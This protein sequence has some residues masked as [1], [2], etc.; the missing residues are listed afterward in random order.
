MATQADRQTEPQA[1]PRMHTQTEFGPYPAGRGARVS[2]LASLL[3]LLGLFHAPMLPPGF[4]P[5]CFMFLISRRSSLIS[6][7]KATFSCTTTAKALGRLDQTQWIECHESAASTATLIN[8]RFITGS[9]PHPLSHPFIH[10]STG[11][12][13]DPPANRRIN[14]PRLCLESG[15]S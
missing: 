14:P 2:G 1:D 11:Q 9:F 3:D 15:P 13:T 5:T 4:S 6:R 10:P 12:P 8:N 7:I